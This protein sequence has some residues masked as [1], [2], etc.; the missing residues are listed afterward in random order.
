MSREKSLVKNTFILSIG[1]FLPKLAAFITLPI[2]TDRMTKNQ[3]GFYELILDLVSLILPTAT[4]QIQT[5]AFRYLLDRREKKE[6]IKSIVTNIYAFILPVSLISLVILYFSF[7]FF[8]TDQ[9]AELKLMI[10]LYFFADILVNAARQVAR[11][12]RK[13]MMYSI[14]AIISA[15]CK[16]VFAVIFVWGLRMNLMGAVLSLFLAS[17]ISF[18]VLVFQLRLYQYIDI[19]LISKQQIK[20]LI[21]YSWGMVPNNM[22]MWVMRVSDRFVILGFLKNYAAVAVYSI[23]NKI[24][25]ILT[26][27]QTTFSMSW[28]E[29]ASIVSKDKDVSAYYSSMFRTMYNLIA[30]FLGLLISMTPILFRILIRGDYLESYPHIPI[31]ILAMFFYTMSTFLGGIY[32]AYMKTK[33][34]GITTTIAAVC[35]ILIN[36]IFIHS[37][38]IYAASISTLVS[39]IL[40]YYYRIFDIQKIVGVQY[41]HGRML[42][43][44]GIMIV[45]C[46]LCM[47]NTLM[48]NILNV[49]IAVVVFVLLNHSLFIAAWDNVRRMV[50]KKLNNR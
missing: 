28:Q 50:Q 19:H 7:Q 36:M 4:L 24:P 8:A 1:T 26:L 11:G 21:S 35:N 23:A 25:S 42:L 20:E 39:Y 33:S 22:S 47:F 18:V 40:L 17:A 46:V 16:I 10:C 30:G 48:L 32:V 27:A 15:I 43:I 41:Q 44:L 5:A 3:Y 49:I 2:L 13:N 38:G 12:L 14:S 31:L 34:V 9:P 29:N 37:I 6:D 45:E